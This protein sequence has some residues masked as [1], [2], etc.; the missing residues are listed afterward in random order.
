M[1]VL[2]VPSVDAAEIVAGGELFSET[3]HEAT[4]LHFEVSVPT[5]YAATI[6]EMCASPTNTMGFIPGLGYVLANQLC[7]V[8][9]AGKAVRFG[10]DWYAAMI[11]VQRDSDIQTLEDLN[12]KKWAYPD[13]ASTSGYLYPIYLFDANGIIPGETVEA[14]SHDAAVKAV[15][16]GEADFGTAFYSPPRVDGTAIDWEPGQ[17]PDVPPDLLDSCATTEDEVTVLCG[18]FEPR[19]ARRNL[20]RE[21]PDVMQK[22]RILETTPKITNDTISFG[23]DFP[24][25]VREQIVNAL[26]EFAENDPDGFETAMAPYDWTDINTATD[27]EYDDIRLAIDASGFNLEDLGE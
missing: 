13:A 16:N 2:F 3:L 15:Y 8:E 11:V 4:G 24:A 22:V 6:E 17:D 23:P 25:D 14:G 5:S 7:G 26:F 20:R 1:K 21:L 12:G 18:N 10:Y 19:D 27:S 9:V